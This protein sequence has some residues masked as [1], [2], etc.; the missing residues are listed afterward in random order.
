MEGPISLTKQEARIAKLILADKTN[1]EIASELYISLST[2]KTHI[3]N[4]YAKYEVSNRQQFAEKMN[5][6]PGD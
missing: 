5:N 4:L 6:Q 3:R 1:K 2:V